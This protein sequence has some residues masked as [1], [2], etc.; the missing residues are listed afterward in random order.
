MFLLLRCVSVVVLWFALPA[1]GYAL[2]PDV[3]FAVLPVGGLASMELSCSLT[4][5]VLQAR[6]APTPRLPTLAVWS[7]SRSLALCSSLKL[8]CCRLEI[9]NIEPGDCAAS[10]E[11]GSTAPGE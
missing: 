7:F 11:V 2:L 8:V 3:G 5:L 1:V 6:L 4:T 9:C 10:V